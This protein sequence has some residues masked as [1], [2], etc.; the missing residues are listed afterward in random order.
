MASYQR[1]SRFGGGKG[2]QRN[3]QDYA[4]NSRF[5]GGKG[6]HRPKKPCANMA[7]DGLCEYGIGCHFSHTVCKKY[8]NC[9]FGASCH[10][11]HP[12]ASADN[13]DDDH[14]YDD[15]AVVQYDIGLLEM[16]DAERAMDDFL[17]REVGDERNLAQPDAFV[18]EHAGC[19]HTF[20]HN[21]CGFCPEQK[22]CEEVICLT[23][24]PL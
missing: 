7:K 3:C 20:E 24:L 12:V 16:E 19:E 2:V 17:S 13:L 4:G 1:N 8:P 11:V 5:G 15:Q 14:V 9:Q 22:V 21:H 23:C 18:C 10:F 6:V